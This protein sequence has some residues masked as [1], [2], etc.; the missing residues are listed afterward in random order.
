MTI[1]GMSSIAMRRIQLILGPEMFIK[2]HSDINAQTL[3]LELPLRGLEPRP[4]P[5]VRILCCNPVAAIGRAGGVDFMRLPD[6]TMPWAPVAVRHDA[7]I[8]AWQLKFVLSSKEEA[9]HARSARSKSKN[10]VWTCNSEWILM[11]RARLTNHLSYAA[12]RI[13]SSS[14]F[15]SSQIF[16]NRTTLKTCVFS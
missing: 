8:A 2:I 16:K 12:F 7:G 5:G 3:R 15:T 10:N 6:C 14:D 9:S 11:R 1:P 4:L 13:N